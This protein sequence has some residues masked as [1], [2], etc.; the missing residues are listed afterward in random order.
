MPEEIQF[1]IPIELL[2]RICN[3]FL[4]MSK[5]GAICHDRYIMDDLDS[6][7]AANDVRY[8]SAQTVN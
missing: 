7:L 1:T 8:K 6:I 3:V 5:Q 2:I 4:D